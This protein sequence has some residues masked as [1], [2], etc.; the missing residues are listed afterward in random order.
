MRT[1]ITK[2]LF[3][4]GHFV[5]RVIEVRLPAAALYGLDLGDQSAAAPNEWRTYGAGGPRRR[6]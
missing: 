5:E 3:A 1:R 6:A 4:V 2:A